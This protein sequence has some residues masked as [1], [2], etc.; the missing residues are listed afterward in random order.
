MLPQSLQL[1]VARF[2]KQTAS[3]KLSLQPCMDIPRAFPKYPLSSSF[4]Y[5]EVDRLEQQRAGVRYHSTSLV[6]V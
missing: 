3:D 4:A 1:F 5:L 2:V 6:A